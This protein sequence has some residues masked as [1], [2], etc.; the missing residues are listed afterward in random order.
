[1]R[2]VITIAVVQWC[3]MD[4]Y[5][6]DLGTVPIPYCVECDEGCA[7]HEIPDTACGHDH[8]Y[9]R[10]LHIPVVAKEEYECIVD[11]FANYRKLQKWW[12]GRYVCSIEPK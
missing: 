7:W 8:T 3:A 1:M 11:E 6:F 5:R 10:T 12:G 2:R 9:Q 4:D